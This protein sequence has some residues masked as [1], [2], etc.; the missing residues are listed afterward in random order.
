MDYEKDIAIDETALDLD[1]LD[2]PALMMKYARHSAQMRK[3]LEEA[4]QNLDIAKA[5][6]DREIREN[7]AKFKIEKVTEGSVASAILTAQKYQDAHKAYLDSKFEADMSQGAVNA[8][9][10]RK[11]ALENL[12]KLHGQQYFAGPRIPHDLTWEREQRQKKS[13]NKVATRMRRS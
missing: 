7:P 6:V 12:V 8:F 13:D 1:W 2:Q 5:E 11:S 10:Q 4:K 9:D 3:N